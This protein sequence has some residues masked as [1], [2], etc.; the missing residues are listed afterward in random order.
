M[1]LISSDRILERSSNVLVA[2]LCEF[3]SACHSS[4]LLLMGNGNELAI[5]LSVCVAK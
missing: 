1:P 4:P 5:R 3:G 2:I